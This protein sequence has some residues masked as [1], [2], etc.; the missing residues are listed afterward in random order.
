[1]QVYLPVMGSCPS[2][3]QPV[4]RLFNNRAD[5]NHRYVTD[6]TLRDQ[7]VAPGWTPEA[8]GPDLVAMC[9]PAQ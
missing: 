1:M 4:Y 6:R 3:A 5:T 2:G 7:M 8:D 9:V